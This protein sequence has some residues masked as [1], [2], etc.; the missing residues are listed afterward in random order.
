MKQEISANEYENAKK[1]IAPWA[2]AEIKKGRV[3]ETFVTWDHIY[4]RTTRSFGH[5][6]T[7]ETF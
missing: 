7:R 3:I 1:D 6:Y 4:R 5:T 2:G